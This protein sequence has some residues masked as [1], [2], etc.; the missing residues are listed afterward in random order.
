MDLMQK[1]VK[2]KIINE[3]FH[4]YGIHSTTLQPEHVR[5]ISGNNQ[6]IEGQ[7]AA[8]LTVDGGVKKHHVLEPNPGCSSETLLTCL[9][10]CGS[11]CEEYAC[12]ISHPKFLIWRDS[13]MSKGHRD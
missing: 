4:A 6:P 13:N 12:L 1:Y 7:E 9:I 8:G 10:N 3:C 2:T 11:T 5:P